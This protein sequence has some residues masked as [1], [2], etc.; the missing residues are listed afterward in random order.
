MRELR[1]ERILAVGKRQHRDLRLTP[2]DRRK[3]E[4]IADQHDLQSAERRGDAPDMPANRIDQAKAPRRKHRDL[5]DHQHARLLDAGRE[6]A[7]GRE[8]VEVA[9]AQVLPHADPTPGMDGHAMAVGRGDAGRGGIGVGDASLL[10]PL[11]IA[12]DGVRLTAAGLP[13]QEDRRAGFEQSER[14]VLCHAFKCPWLG[15]EASLSRRRHRQQVEHDSCRARRPTCHSSDDLPP[16]LPLVG[17]SA[18][19]L[20]AG[21]GVLHFVC[22]LRASRKNRR[23]ITGRA[24]VTGS[25]GP[26][27]AKP[28]F[29]SAKAG[30]PGDDKKGDGGAI[31]GP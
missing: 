7:I 25:P 26:A 22:E 15:A 17:R 20:R 28:S 23:R 30:K 29:A 5:V 2:H 14:F 3:L 18:R 31:L 1:A 10:Q 24:G 27:C 9:R 19:L 12:V 11:Q 16:N 21:W 8:Q 6:P 4:E 13:G